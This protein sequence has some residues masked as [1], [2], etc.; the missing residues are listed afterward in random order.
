MPLTMGHIEPPEAGDSPAGVAR[1]V[2]SG[3]AGQD[4]NVHTTSDGVI[5]PLHWVKGHGWQHADGSPVKTP[6]TS[7]TLAEARELR[8]SRTPSAR[9]VPVTEILDTLPAGFIACLEAKPDERLED[10]ATW[11]QVAKHPVIVMTIQQYGRTPASRARWEAKAQRRLRAAHAAGLPTMLLWR[12]HIPADSPWWDGFLTSVKGAPKSQSLPE[13][14][15]RVPKSVPS[16]SEARLALASV[17]A[18]GPTPTTTSPEAPAML[19]SQ[20]GWP[21]LDSTSTRLHTWIIPART[22]SLR[23]RVREGSAGFLLAHFALW[24]AET[25]EPLRG[26]VADDWGYASRPIRGQATGLSN[27]AAGCA[28]D[29]NATR[30]ALGKRGTFGRTKAARI[31]ARLALYKGCLRWGG[32]YTRRADEMHFEVVQSLASCETVAR[33]LMSTPRGQRLLLANPSQKAVILS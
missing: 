9:I 1:S 11:G 17:I 8:N 19:M 29:L 10:P 16:M 32:Q 7:M 20:N 26:K 24:F 2:A 12:E 22:G 6:I 18:A 21:A 27:H 3:L 15:I 4:V 13:G 31:V 25:I 23:L 28:I 33:R 14:V 30:H 5:V